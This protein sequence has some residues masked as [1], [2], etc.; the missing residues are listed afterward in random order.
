MRK[1]GTLLRN[2]IVSISIYLIS[3]WH[4]PNFKKFIT[5]CHS[6]RLDCQCTDH[7]PLSRYY[8][9]HNLPC[10]VCANCLT[11]FVITQVQRSALFPLHHLLY[12][13]LT[14]RVTYKL[15]WGDHVHAPTTG[16]HHFHWP[17]MKTK[18][19]LKLSWD[20]LITGGT[21]TMTFYTVQ[22][23]GFQISNY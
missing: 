1:G 13:Y 11:E 2:R 3:I 20:K 14:G 9:K 10:I 18:P 23:Y 6:N 21:C 15:K 4:C 22:N 8:H 17:Y 7:H 16:L 5:L 19:Y 12:W